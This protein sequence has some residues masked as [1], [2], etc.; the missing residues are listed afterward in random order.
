MAKNVSQIQITPQFEQ[1]GLFFECQT[2][3]FTYARL[4]NQVPLVLGTKK[5]YDDDFGNFDDNDEQKNIQISRLLNQNLQILGAF[6][7]YKA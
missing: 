3:C 4:Q 6:R 7:D 5:S 2:Q 1:S